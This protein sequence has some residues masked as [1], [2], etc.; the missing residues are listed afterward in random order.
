MKR[1]AHSWAIGL[2]TSLILT[3]LAWS[4]PVAA[5]PREKTQNWHGTL[6]AGPARL[7]LQFAW[8]AGD[9]GGWQGNITS[10]DQGNI[11]IP[12]TSI[13]FQDG[14]WTLKAQSVGG[15]FVGAASED[16]QSLQGTWKQNGMEF[17]LQLKKGLFADADKEAGKLVD[18]W[19]GSIDVAG[20]K[21][22]LQVR[23]LQN[24][25]GEEEVLFDSLTQ[26]AM[27][28]AA[29]LDV[30]GTDVTLRVPAIMGKF[31]GKLNDAGDQATGT[32]EQLGN[33]FPLEL[34]KV[35]QA[36]EATPLERP[37]NPKKPYPY[38]EEDARFKNSKAGIVLVGTLTLPAEKGPGYPAVV[39]VSGSGPQ[40]RDESLM[41]HKPFLVI[42][43]YLT[44]QGIAV[45]RY[46]DRGNG[47]SEGEFGT[48]TTR[49]FADDAAAAVDFLKSH[50]E[51][52]GGRIGI[53]GHS[54]GGLIAPI[55]ASELIP[56]LAHIVLLAGPGVDGGVILDT[57]V[58]AIQEAMG[59][60]NEMIGEQG[61]RL[62]KIVQAIRDNISEEAFARLIEEQLEA[63]QPQDAAAE[64][65]EDEAA[66]LAKNASE[67][68]SRLQLQQMST[69]WFR[70]FITYDPIPALEK[71]SCPVL[72]L[73]GEKDL[74][75][76]VDVNL[77]AIEAA[78]QRG[79]N[80]GSRCVRLAGLN[81]LFQ[82]C[83]T[84]S[85]MEYQMISQTCAP[86][87]LEIMAAWI[88]EH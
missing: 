45:L 9:G 3:G 87:A 71:V 16:Q 66:R 44:R 2:A 14:Q 53:I 20:Q 41:G 33:K 52:D 17:P 40:D 31:T 46:D 69:P 62:A 13:Q 88:K 30:D 43:D 5:P 4:Q 11:K 22:E 59:S 38:R 19:R 34:R 25:D 39:L 48:A 78:L 68:L 58:R 23:R 84:G 56:D 42:A 55:V 79:G 37:Q 28:V 18:A 49:D 6:Q 51:V 63:S 27:G 57:Q 70:Y 35:E 86:E 7:R 72:A 15:S 10:L 75:V 1:T 29:T 77:P 47:A 82:E 60:E 24:E 21:L 67:S 73:N 74:Q 36:A 81:H 64:P 83:T 54:E 85:P 26:Q 65:E 76:V 61:A 32:W 8:Q 12:L 50:P 80:T